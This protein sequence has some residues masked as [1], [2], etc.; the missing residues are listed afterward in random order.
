MF[1]SEP[2]A[3]PATSSAG[4]DSGAAI[5]AHSTEAG[6]QTLARYRSGRNKKRRS[7]LRR[8]GVSTLGRMVAMRFQT[9]ERSHQVAESGLL[10][11]WLGLPEDSAADVNGGPKGPIVDQKP[12][13]W[14]PLANEPL[15]IARVGSKPF[16][17]G[18]RPFAQDPF[19]NVVKHLYLVSPM[20][21]KCSP[22]KTAD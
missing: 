2:I 17:R 12:A 10:Q 8:R 3:L 11:R 5:S 13:G 19:R 18:F 22:G 20:D 6:R 9:L 7:S 1:H 21:H 16:G 4:G 15:Q 14:W